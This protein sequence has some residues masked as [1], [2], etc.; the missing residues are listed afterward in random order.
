MNIAF[1]GFRHGHIYSL[2]D[3]AVNNPDVQILGAY[4]S[5]KEARETAYNKIGVNFTH[6]DLGELL[7]EKDL[8][9]VAI[10]DYFQIR[11]S[12]AIAALKAGKHVIS[13]KPLCTS[14]QEL[15]EITRLSKEKNLAVGMMLD[16]RFNNNALHVYRLVSEGVIGEIQNVFFSGQHP[17]SYGIRPA[18][19]FEPGK[20]GGTIN[21]IAIHG[22]DLI[23]HLTGLSLKKILYARCWN[24]YATEKTEFKDC[25]QF[26]V[27]M[28]NG[29]GLMADVSYS[30]PNSFG[31]SL[32]T[33]WRFTLWGIKGFIEFN[34]TTDEIIVAIDGENKI[35][36]IKTQDTN[37]GNTLTAF[38]SEI[39]GESTSL[40]TATVLK[41]TRDAL[42][43]QQACV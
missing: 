41:A 15:D 16:L 9:A 22:I 21:D 10:G 28:S 40:N 39:D 24:A 27:E 37:S 6:D 12:H 34:I 20:H 30:S 25:A 29:A 8:D 11:G 3:Q 2:Y 35:Q 1:I 42:L 23:E 17:L 14:L 43:I 7:G 38:I 13:D 26:M 5:N 31:F 32:P 18:W 33:Y 19:Y 4:E 36:T